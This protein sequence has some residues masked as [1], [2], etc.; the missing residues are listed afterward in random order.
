MGYEIKLIIGKSSLAS[1]EIERDKELKY[2]DGN[3]HPYKRDD[4]GQFVKTGRT[5]HYF[6]AMASLDLCKLGYQDDALNRLIAQSF[7]KGKEM[8]SKEFHYFYEADGNTQLT[9]D[10]YGAVFWPVPVESVLSAM[11]E[12]HGDSEYRRAKWAIA[13]LASMANDQEALEVIFFGH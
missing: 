1:E 12:S 7:D 6:M 8:N 4:K 2:A 11:I 10:K 3:G 9:E 5:E 13:L